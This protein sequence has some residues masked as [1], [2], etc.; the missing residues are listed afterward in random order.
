MAPRRLALILLA[1]VAQGGM[2]REGARAQNP[3]GF[4]QGTLW[5]C[6]LPLDGNDCSGG[7]E[8]AMLESWV[9]PHDVAL[10]SPIV[11]TVW[12]DIDFGRTAKSGGWLGRG[13]PRFVRVGPGPDPDLV[14]LAHHLATGDLPASFVLAI[15]VTYVRNTTESPLPVH[16]CTASDDSIQVWVNNGLVLNQSVCRTVTPSCSE[17]TPAVLAPGVNRLTVL[18]WQGIGGFGFRL[19]LSRSDGTPYTERD[20]E[21]E[22]LGARESPGS[23]PRLPLLTRTWTGSEFLRP[24]ESHEVRISGDGR[25]NPAA[26]YRVCEELRGR[27]APDDVGSTTTGSS[28]TALPTEVPRAG[29]FH[30]GVVGIPCAADNRTTVEGDIYTTHARTGGDIWAAGD[31]FEF[32]YLRQMGT[33]TWPWRSSTGAF[34]PRGDGGSSG[35]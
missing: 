16:I 31:T 14:D 2:V 8:R 11:G 15:A 19:G 13:A 30:H 28:I 24:G 18:V 29:W 7:G 27:V 3:D 1:L 22:Y 5:A 34:P 33:S 4:L 20:S 32:A 17:L 21:I 6:L 23:V 12:S 26:T 25:F 9:A 10:E 35:S